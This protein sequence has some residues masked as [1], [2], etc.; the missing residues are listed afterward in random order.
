MAGVEVPLL[1]ARSIPVSA[2]IAPTLNM[3]V[4]VDV[5]VIVLPHMIPCGRQVCHISHALVY[6]GLGLDILLSLGVKCHRGGFRVGVGIA[7]SD[8]EPV[9]QDEFHVGIDTPNLRTVDV[10]ALTNGG[11]SFCV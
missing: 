6:R 5:Q 11:P 2:A 3:P 7:G 4:E 10:V 1:I 8:G 9:W